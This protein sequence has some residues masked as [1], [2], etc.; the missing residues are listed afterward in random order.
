MEHV[1]FLEY[2]DDFGN[3]YPS[4]RYNSF[5]GIAGVNYEAE[6]AETGKNDT[7]AT[8][9]PPPAPIAVYPPKIQGFFMTA[10]GN[11]KSKTAIFFA[12]NGFA[13]SSPKTE[14]RCSI[15][16]GNLITIQQDIATITSD[17]FGMASHLSEVQDLMAEYNE[18]CQQMQTQEDTG[19]SPI[20]DTDFTPHPTDGNPNTYYPPPSTPPVYGSM[21]VSGGMPMG[22]DDMSVYC[23]QVP[24]DPACSQ[25]GGLLDKAKGL[26]WILIAGVGVAGFFAYK[27]FTKKGK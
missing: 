26:N 6:E 4:E 2:K 24:D 12:Y 15:N 3:F 23:S 21:P 20:G 11:K 25:G 7:T 8:P 13:K 17:P 18:G 19:Q 1:G 22:G 5:R 10:S 27:Y 9:P 14:A 16:Y